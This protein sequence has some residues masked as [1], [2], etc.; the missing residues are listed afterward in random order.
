M[1]ISGHP[2]VFVGVV[3][4]LPLPGGPGPSQGL[5]AVVERAQRDAAALAAGGADALIVENLGDHPFG[6]GSVEP[7]TVAAMTRAVLAVREAAPH[8]GLGINVL[9]NDATAALS[10]A[11]ATTADFIRVNVHTGAMVTDQGIIEGQ[12]RDTLILRQRL[13]VSTLIVADVLVKHAV[14]LGAWTIE[15]AARDTAQRGRADV[16]V[17]TGDGTG[18]PTDPSVYERVQHATS[19]PVWVGSGLKPQQVQQFAQLDGAI[20]GTWLHQESDLERPL[21]PTRIGAMRQALSKSA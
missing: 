16:I 7:F 4:L 6:R 3:H 17:V 18:S 10:I 21:D 1:R 15:T 11:A 9:R 8:I 13:G 12:A 2:P 20:V 19:R 5:Q 14:P